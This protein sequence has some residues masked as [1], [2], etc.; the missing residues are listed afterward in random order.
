MSILAFYIIKLEAHIIWATLV[1]E[2]S[3]DMTGLEKE[4]YLDFLFSKQP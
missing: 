1:V 4:K 2:V 3:K